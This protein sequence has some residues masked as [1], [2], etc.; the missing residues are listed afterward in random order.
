MKKL[1]VFTILA[2]PTIVF[3]HGDIATDSGNSWNMMNWSWGN[4]GGMMGGM[5]LWGI[6]ML[7]TWI[8]WLVVGVLAS[9][10]FWK[11]ISKK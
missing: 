7:F 11:K 6:L 1:I 4:N 9:I 5:G 10:W 2:L 3:A 8:V